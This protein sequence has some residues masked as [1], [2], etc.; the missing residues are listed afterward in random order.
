MELPQQFALA[1]AHVLLLSAQNSGDSR[2]SNV[3]C[4]GDGALSLPV[5]DQV[6]DEF[7]PV[8]RRDYRYIYGDVQRFPDACLYKNSDMETF[9]E[10]LKLAR[11]EAHLSQSEAA[12][13]VGM[14]QPTLSGLEKGGSASSTYTPLLAT[15]YG[16]SAIW[17]AE[18]KGP[19]RPSFAGQPESEAQESPAYSV[20]AAELAKQ[21]DAAGPAKRAA[22]D[23]LAALPESEM[24]PIYLLLQ[25][26]GAKYAVDD[27]SLQ[28]AE[29]I[30][31]RPGFYKVGGVTFFVKPEGVVGSTESPDAKA[32]RF[33]REMERKAA[34]N[35]I[36]TRRAATEEK[37]KPGDQKKREAQ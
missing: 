28:N 11:S 30:E 3:Y 26:I 33:Q 35:K 18:G 14:K 17:L 10:R 2:L 6:I 36:P 23:A 22:L 32:L 8:H 7:C 37:L 13:R 9:S 1:P 16:V 5:G 19:Q 20:D 21:Y 15:L 24:G 29:P 25:S 12:R 4:L 34:L 31:G 27:E